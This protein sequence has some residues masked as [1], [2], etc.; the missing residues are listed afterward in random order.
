MRTSRESSDCTGKSEEYPVSHVLRRVGCHQSKGQVRIASQKNN[1]SFSFLSSGPQR[2]CR[3]L[4]LQQAAAPCSQLVRKSRLRPS[5]SV[6]SRRPSYPTVAPGEESSGDKK[7][8][9]RKRGKE[10]GPRGAGGSGKGMPTPVFYQLWL[11]GVEAGGKVYSADSLVGNTW[12]AEPPS[13]LMHP[14][15]SGL[16]GK[17]SIYKPPTSGDLAAAGWL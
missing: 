3:L 6:G 13:P 4:P 7:L 5:T 12:E 10:E 16:R 17:C 1:H 11:A 9:W 15:F 14:S 2:S 8:P